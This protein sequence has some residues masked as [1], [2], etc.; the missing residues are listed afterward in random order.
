MAFALVLT[1]DDMAL[2]EMC[3]AHT[4]QTGPDRTI[5]NRILNGGLAQWATASRVPTTHPYY[6]NDP[7]LIF[8]V[9]DAPVTL[10]ELRAYIVT[11]SQKYAWASQIGSL[12]YHMGDRSFAVEPWPWLPLGEDPWAGIPR[13]PSRVAP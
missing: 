1:L 13:E 11:F 7:E 2:V 12:A 10:A 4:G 5:S 9:V 3:L 6:D 8:L